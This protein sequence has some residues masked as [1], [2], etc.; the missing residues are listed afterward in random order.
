MLRFDRAQ[1]AARAGPLS[2]WL[3][4]WLSRQEQRR[5]ELRTHLALCREAAEL[6]AF[7]R[8]ASTLARDL[9]T[10]HDYAD[11]QQ[12]QRRSQHS[13]SSSTADVAGQGAPEPEPEPELEPESEPGDEAGEPARIGVGKLYHL[14]VI[15]IMTR[16]LDWLSF[17]YVLR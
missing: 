16:T 2:H 3:A 11:Q 1:A 17:T 9:L 5:E 4:G 13:E 10:A 8:Q 14:R 6:A 12:Q 15:M 7:A